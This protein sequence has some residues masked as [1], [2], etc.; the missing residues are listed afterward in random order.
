VPEAVGGGSE[1]DRHERV[2]GRRLVEAIAV[3]KHV[4]DHRLACD[5]RQVLVHE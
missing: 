5:L 3:L 2:S 4:I 1:L